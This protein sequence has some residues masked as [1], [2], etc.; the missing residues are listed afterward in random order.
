M[1]NFGDK[2]PENVAGK[3]YVDRTCIYCGLCDMTAPT[4]FRECNEQGWAYVFHQPM[5]SEELAAC[6]QALEG[7]PTSSI[8][9]DGK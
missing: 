7:C 4:V 5:T 8:G 6:I 3:F 1:A 2:V 9:N